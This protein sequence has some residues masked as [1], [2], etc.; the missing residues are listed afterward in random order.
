[1]SSGEPIPWTDAMATAEELR[2]L[3]APACERI[4]VAGS[5]RRRRPTVSDIELVAMPRFVDE[6]DGLFDTARHSALDA[7]LGDI[8]RRPVTLHR[9]DG[10]EQE[11]VRDG[12]A[13]KALQYRGLPVDLF[14]VDPERS[15]WGVIFT[16]RTGPADFAHELVARCRTWGRRVQGGRLYD[17]GRYVPCPEETDFLAAVGLPW[18][19]PWDR[20]P[21]A[22]R[23]LMWSTTWTK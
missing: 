14:I 7:L 4:E 18:I 23:N 8:E 10:T 2:S 13:Y 12:T 22:V 5:L 6:Q 3:L 16:I 1:M 15:D 19:E 11:Q 17:R 9:H 20:T 21:G